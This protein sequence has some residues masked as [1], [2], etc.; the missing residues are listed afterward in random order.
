[1]RARMTNQAGDLR[2]AGMTAALAAGLARATTGA[3]RPPRA[4]MAGAVAAISMTA[5]PLI[6][7]AP[8]HNAGTSR[9]AVT[10]TTTAR[11]VDSA[12]RRVAAIPPD[13][14]DSGGVPGPG[15]CWAAGPGQS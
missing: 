11:C 2:A 6:Q 12:H 9:E 5:G 15:A 10:S 14:A 1:M 7:I 3:A 8:A 4:A 13:R